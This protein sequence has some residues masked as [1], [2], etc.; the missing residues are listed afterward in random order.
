MH[1]AYAKISVDPG[2]FVPASPEVDT[3]KK[4]FTPAFFNLSAAAVFVFAVTNGLKSD[5]VFVTC[6]IVTIPGIL[7]LLVFVDSELT[8]SYISVTVPFAF[9]ASRDFFD[10]IGLELSNEISSV[11]PAD[12]PATADWTAALK[13]SSRI[14]EYTDFDESNRSVSCVCS[15]NASSLCSLFPPVTSSACTVDAPVNVSAAATIAKHDFPKIFCFII[16]SFF[17]IY[18][19]F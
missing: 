1:I 10:N 9:I 12:I 16:S 7:V 8:T 19:V 6:L 17:I 14:S 5:D 13:S 15:I 18:K 2:S 11:S 3:V 4:C